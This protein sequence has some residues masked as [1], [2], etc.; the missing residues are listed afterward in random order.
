MRRLRVSHSNV[1]GMTRGTAAVVEALGSNIDVD[2]EVHRTRLACR[3]GPPRG[4]M[5]HAWGVGGSLAVG[6]S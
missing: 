5:A 3:E 4:W 2:G 1:P 6:M